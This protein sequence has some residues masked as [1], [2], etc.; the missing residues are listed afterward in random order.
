MKELG[1]W[2]GDG[3]WIQ[4]EILAS[5]DWNTCKGEVPHWNSVTNFS[6]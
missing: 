3:T 5:K 6:F 1:Q 2:E 4:G